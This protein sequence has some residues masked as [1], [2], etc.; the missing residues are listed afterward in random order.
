[1]T[2]PR[3]QMGKKVQHKTDMD[4]EQ[5]D[6]LFTTGF[7]HMLSGAIKTNKQWYHRYYPLEA[8]SVQYAEI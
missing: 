1:M 3:H 2:Q 4:E 8:I 5:D 6:K 7:V